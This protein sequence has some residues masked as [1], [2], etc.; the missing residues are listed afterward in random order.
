MRYSEI[1]TSNQDLLQF[2][3]GNEILNY[4]FIDLF[5]FFESENMINLI[6]KQEIECFLG[7]ERVFIKLF[8]C[9]YILYFMK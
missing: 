3:E 5:N 1:E 6:N 7:E 8:N 2:Y 4:E 9:I